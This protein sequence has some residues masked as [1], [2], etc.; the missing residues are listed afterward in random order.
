MRGRHATPHLLVILVIMTRFINAGRS[1]RLIPPTLHRLVRKSTLRQR[2]GVQHVKLSLRGTAIAE[3]WKKAHPR[4]TVTRGEFSC[5]PLV[6]Q[7]SVEVE[8][9]NKGSSFSSENTTTI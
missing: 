4:F 9:R 6:I 3:G 1:T 5:N 2:G 8:N 7:N